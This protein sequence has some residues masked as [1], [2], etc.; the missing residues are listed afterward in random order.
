[1]DNVPAHVYSIRASKNGIVHYLIC[2]TGYASAHIIGGDSL[3]LQ[4]YSVQIL[5]DGHPC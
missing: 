5:C 3:R 4:G 1:M 2:M